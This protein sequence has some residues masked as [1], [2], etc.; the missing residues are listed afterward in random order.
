M[1]LQWALNRL[2]V[3]GAREVGFRGTRHLRAQLER[4]GLGAATP[5]PAGTGRGRPWV[6]PLPQGFST[7][8]YR[9]AA[10]STLRGEFCLFGRPQTLGFPPRWNRDPKTGREGR[11]GFG[12]SLDYRNEQ[13]FGDIKY[14]WEP[15]RHLELTTLAQTWRLTGEARFAEAVRTLVDSWLQ[16][17]PYPLGPNWTSSLEV[18]LRLANWSCT[19]HLLGGDDAVVFHDASQPGFKDRWL[20][21]VRQH[22]HFISGYLSA[23]SSANNHLLGELLGLLLGATT[24]PCWPESAQWRAYA[25]EQ[26]E[27]QALMQNWPDGVNKEQAIWYQHEVA[28]MMLMAGL[29]ARANDCEF[30]PAFWQRLEMMLEFIASCMDTAGNVPA[31]GDSDDAVIVRFVPGSSSDA[32]HSLLA[33]GS[34]LFERGDFKYKARVFDDKS[35]WL[36]GDAAA[37]RFSAIAAEFPGRRLPRAFAAGGYYILGSDFETPQEVR[38][39]VDA[40]PLGYLAIAAHGHADALAFTLSAA[41]CPLLI[42]PGTYCYHTQKRW[43]DYFRGTAAHNTV[44]VDGQDQSLSGGNFLWMRHARTR[45][46]S[47]DLSG[48][49]QRVVAEHDGYERLP[50]PVTHRREILYDATAG[51]LRVTDYLECAGKHYVEVLWHFAPE[52]A[53]SLEGAAATAACGAAKLQMRWPAQLRGAV[54]RGQ[55]QPCLGWFSAHYDEK[56]PSPT[57]VLSGEVVGSWQ[58]TTE[59]QI[60]FAT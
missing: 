40:A 19:W 43:R 53:L 27:R 44:L 37:A 47:V 29:V 46:L 18:G 24:W 51:C 26:F 57:L 13:Q 50:D 6:S 15:N 25:H 48:A 30:S 4:Y 39:I 14:L 42:D 45:C 58:A 20:A 10:E 41:G 23:Y 60:E 7:D 33:S 38:V 11:L 52:C 8:V 36:L 31:L 5:R 54:V 21:G 49:I 17:C 3:A 1:K 9:A 16:Q 2:R 56:T 32:Y 22:C 28:D 55:T 34:V 12:K 35:R 59:M